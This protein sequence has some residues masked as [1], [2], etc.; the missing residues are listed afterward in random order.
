MRLKRNAQSEKRILARRE[1]RKLDLRVRLRPPLIAQ[2][3]AVAHRTDPG[4]SQRLRKPFRRNG[5]HVIGVGLIFGHDLVDVIRAGDN[6]RLLRRS[7]RKP[8]VVV[9]VRRGEILAARDG[10][11]GAFE[12][13]NCVLDRMR[14]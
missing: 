13:R 7:G 9:D 1:A 11:I 12:L 10:E 2:V 4:P 14:P 6:H 8:D 3:L 5:D